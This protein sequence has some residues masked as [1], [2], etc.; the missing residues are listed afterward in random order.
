VSWGYPWK[1]SEHS[2]LP[3]AMT[4]FSFC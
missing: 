1:W 2:Q 4:L 3:F